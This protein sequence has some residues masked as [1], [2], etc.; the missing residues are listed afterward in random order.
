MLHGEKLYTLF[1]RSQKM[2]TPKST[3]KNSRKK[4]QETQKTNW[5]FYLLFLCFLCLFAANYT[6]AYSGGDGSPENPYQIA[7]VNN[8]L[9]LAADTGNYDK[10]FILTAD[11]NLAGYDFNGAVIAQYTSDQYGTHGIPFC[12]SFDGACHK[13]SNL[14]INITGEQYS[15]YVCCGLFGQTNLISDEFGNPL[16]EIKNLTLENVHISV[17]DNSSIIGG[18]V[19]DNEGVPI[20]NCCI[21]INGNSYSKYIG[22]LVGYN[23]GN[24]NNCFS[25]GNIFITSTPGMDAL[26]AAGGL[27]GHNYTSNIINNSHSDCNVSCDANNIAGYVFIGGLVGRNESLDDFGY[28]NINNCYSTG[29]VCGNGY[30]AGYFMIG[31]FIGKNGRSYYDQQSTANQCFSI[32]HVMV[33]V[34]GPSVETSIGGLVGYNMGEIND[35]Y[36]IGP[37]T[38]P[39]SDYDGLGGLVGTN[40]GYQSLPAIIRNCYSVGKVNVLGSSEYSGGLVGYQYE[41]VGSII[42]SYYLDVNGPING[43]NLGTPLT[44]PNMKK[45]AS[46]VGWDFVGETINGTE[47]VWWILENITYP[48]LNWQ[49]YLPPGPCGPGEPDDGGIYFPDYNFDGIV[50][51]V[52]F[53]IFADAWLTE[54]P[55]ISLDGDNYVDINDLK[56]FC[57]H[58]LEWRP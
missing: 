35:C 52:D 31:G 1:L 2:N 49:R 8:L 55:F 56:I 36:S 39:A 16:S 48:K 41:G 15:G 3:A 29:T 7:D 23:N 33:T 10:F 28:S 26:M 45:Q 47:D 46:F 20:T 32:S 37:V 11:I 17:T 42:S 6:Y 51:F 58:W 13:I 57:D 43:N 4:A 34:M 22:G 40:S 30:M 54:N 5:F 14:T 21:N 53:A 24:I 38:G 12:G 50:N 25:E 9:Q 18:L 27:I 44:D 19:G